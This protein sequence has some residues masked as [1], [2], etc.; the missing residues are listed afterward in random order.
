MSFLVAS[1]KKVEEGEVSHNKDERI[2]KGKPGIQKRTK[3]MEPDIA[4]GM[5]FAYFNSWTIIIDEGILYDYG[6]MEHK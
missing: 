3:L 4:V 1:S 2:D 6:N 5:C